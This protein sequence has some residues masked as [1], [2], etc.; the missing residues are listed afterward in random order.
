MSGLWYKFMTSH[1]IYVP[2]GTI[3][4]YRI[5]STKAG[6]EL[7]EAINQYFKGEQWMFVSPET[8]V[9]L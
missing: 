6:E 8:V 9:T 4:F 2:N 7:V 5:R 1:I 3:T